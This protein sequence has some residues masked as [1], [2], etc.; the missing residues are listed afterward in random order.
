MRTGDSVIYLSDT[1]PDYTGQK[2]IAVDFDLQN[3][4]VNLQCA[5]GNLI[6]AFWD[7]IAPQT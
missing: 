3:R 5:D 2:V 6:W 7:E 1:Q 4:L